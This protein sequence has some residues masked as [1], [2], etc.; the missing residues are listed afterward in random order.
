MK[1]FCLGRPLAPAILILEDILQVAVV[2][3]DVTKLQRAYFRSSSSTMTS[4]LCALVLTPVYCE[5][6][7]D[8]C[9]L[10]EHITTKAA[11]QTTHIFCIC[12]MQNMD[13]ALLFCILFCIC[14]TFVYILL[15]IIWHIFA[16]FAYPT[17]N[18]CTMSKIWIPYYYFK[19]LFACYAYL[20]A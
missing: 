16:Y 5:N 14:C 19:Y 9:V 13:P 7:P 15:Y 1:D 11:A 2:F 12:N 10:R 20:F 3:Q 8:S 4:L 17:C 6:T 18:I